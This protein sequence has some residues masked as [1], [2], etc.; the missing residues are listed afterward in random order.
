M[1]TVI[2]IAAAVAAHIVLGID[3]GD[4][5]RKIYAAHQVRSQRGQTCRQQKISIQIH[6]T[7]HLLFPPGRAVV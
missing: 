6:N 2:I 3:P 5:H 4:Q 1:L 7:P